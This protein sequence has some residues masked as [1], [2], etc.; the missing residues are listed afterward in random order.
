MAAIV[1]QQSNPTLNENNKKCNPKSSCWPFLP[2]L[3]YHS[4]FF[5]MWQISLSQK[6]HGN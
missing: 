5:A 4:N 3:T 1:S 6:S 2:S